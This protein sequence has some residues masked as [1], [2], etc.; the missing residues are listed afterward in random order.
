MQQKLLPYQL[1]I[2]TTITLFFFSTSSILCRM[3]LVE[4]SIDAYSFTFFRLFFGAVVLMGILYYKS[5]IVS[6][7]FKTNWAS[8]TMLFIYAICFS[9]AY[10]NL[11]AGLGAL[12]L[13]AVVQLTIIVS[14]LLN[15][16]RI[17]LLKFIGIAIAFTGLFYLLYPKEDFELSL[18]H[19]G[20]MVVS[21]IAWGGYTLLG[22]KSTNALYHTTDNFIKATLLMTLSFVLLYEGHHITT[23]GIFLAFV[24]GGI[25][26]ALGYALWYYILPQIAITTSGVVQLIVPVIA[27]FLG[28]LLLDEVVTLTLIIATISILTGIALCIYSK[29]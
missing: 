20:L 14:A 23:T 26:S 29:N 19:V 24:S 8:A 17:N 15:K 16:E 28:V 27:I 22:K 21:G 1:V 11:D 13:F 9:F 12:I 5:K 10:I 2:L 3:A 6:I 7:N 4:N 25:T 18:F